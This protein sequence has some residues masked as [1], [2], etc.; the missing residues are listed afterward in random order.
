MTTALKARLMLVGL[1]LAWGL[2]WPAMR[3]ALID[4]PPLSMR[5]VAALIGATTTFA[6]AALAGRPVRVPPKPVW[7]YI[8][9]VS[10]FNI[11]LFSLCVAFAQLH[12]MTGR[13]AILVYTMTRNS[14]RQRSRKMSNGLPRSTFH[15]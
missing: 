12:T 2:T 9:I 4:F 8:F 7:G 5:A 15:A 1:C 11:I 14:P 13:V 10:F 6:I 3:I